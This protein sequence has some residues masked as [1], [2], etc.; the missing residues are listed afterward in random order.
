MMKNTFFAA[1]SVF[2]LSTA[3]SM[4]SAAD[5]YRRDATS[6]RD[7][8]VP[9]QSWTGFYLGGH[10]GGAWSTVDFNDSW[11]LA[12]NVTNRGRFSAD[13]AIGGVQFG[14]NLQR[15]PLVYGI[16][17]DLGG[18][19][20]SGGKSFLP[21]GI[22]E[23]SSTRFYGDITGRMGYAAGP[24]L[25]YLKGGA[26]FLN[27]NFKLDALGSG[28]VLHSFSENDTL[29][30]WT[31]GGGVEYKLH[32]RWS[33]KAEYRHFDFGNTSLDWV[34]SKVKFS[35]AADAVTLGVSYHLNR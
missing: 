33:N 2:A 15:G 13:G 18:M 10:A 23:S 26:A 35:P 7:E 9:V 11:N 24:A 29:W 22:E 27:G 4:A 32:P 6:V 25:F 16:E 30:G 14:Y 1:G 20:L 34:N 17:A 5:V 19:G 12:P 21:Y 28:G 8:V 3:A 31:L